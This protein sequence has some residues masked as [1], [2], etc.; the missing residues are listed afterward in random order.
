VSVAQSCHTD[1]LHCIFAFLDMK[2]LLPALQSCR[3]WHAAG[4]T[5][6]PLGLSI[7]LPPAFA[8]EL[9]ASPFRHHVVA[10]T[11]DY[12]SMQ[13]DQLRLL[14]AL[15]RLTALHV[16]VEGDQLDTLIGSEADLPE[17]RAQQLRDAFPPQLHNLSLIRASDLPI[18][19]ALVD[20]LLTLPVLNALQ[21]GSAFSAVHLAPLL[22]LP[23]LSSLSLW[24][25][26]SD[27]QIAVIK[28]LG[29]LSSLEP[30]HGW[31][32]ATLLQL[33]TP[34]H[35][36]QRLEEVTIAPDEIVEQPLIAA[37]MQLPVLT[38]LKAD[39]VRPGCWAGL[40]G[41]TQLRTLWLGWPY[42]SALSD[43]SVLAS[44]I[45]AMPL[46]TDLRIELS[47]G[48]SFA[49]R[50]PALRRLELFNTNV[51]SLSCLHHSPLLESLRL[52][53]C[54]HLDIDELAQCLHTHAPQLR[55]LHIDRGQNLIDE[56][57]A[58][59]A[60]RALLPALGEFKYNEW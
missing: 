38:S 33:L 27:E 46:L 48:G 25:D 29:G 49:L 2:E 24:A 57:S 34:P 14:R 6:P 37:L 45:N 28:Q 44:S 36:L 22:Q 7:R 52:S 21:L 10:L 35:S 31:K 39:R 54:R 58:L 12:S 18:S 15:P 4:L 19:Q 60:L 59:V 8:A 26:L 53:A 51:P 30:G 1:A 47:R 32:S 23:R 5:Q 16:R 9:V 43:C 56:Q 20:A 17:R 41:L 40:G 50:L 3:N 42:S 13:L 11:V 55:C